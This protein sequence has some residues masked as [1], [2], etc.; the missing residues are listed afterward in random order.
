MLTPELRS[1]MHAQLYLWLD[2]LAFSPRFSSRVRPHLLMTTAASLY[3][4]WMEYAATKNGRYPYPMLD[5]MSPSHRSLF[6]VFQVPT[7][8]ALYHAANYVH[9]L[10]RGESSNSEENEAR[11]VRRAENKLADKAQ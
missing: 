9:G 10:V 11:K 4:L 7:L 5:D 1:M 6:Y 2:F 8:I 3:V